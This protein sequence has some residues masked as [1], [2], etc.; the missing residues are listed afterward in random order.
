MVT[1]SNNKTK[2]AIGAVFFSVLIFGAGFYYG[3]VHQLEHGNNA[4]TVAPRGEISQDANFGTFWEAWSVL[5]EK[6]V[7]ANPSSGT[8]TSTTTDQERVYGAIQGMTESLGDPYTLFL[9]PSEN[10]V[11]EGN[12]Q[13]EFGGVGMEV[14]QR[15]GVL[16]VI[17]PLPDTPAQ[18]A[19]LEPNDK[20]LSIGGESTE[21]MSVQNAVQLIRGEKGTDVELTILSEGSQEPRE[22]AV[23]RSTIQIPTIETAETN[24]AYVI[25]LYNFSAKSPEAFRNA[26]QEFEQSGKD[27][28]VIDLRGNAGGFLQ[29]AVDVS[30]H[31]VDKE[32]VVVRESF[33]DKRDP[34]VHRSNG[35]DL[36]SEDTN[37]A[38]LVNEGSASAS[39]IVAGALR[40]HGVARL[41]GTSTF[42]KG[43]VQELVELSDN[44]ALKVTV[45]RWFTPDDT[46]ISD[47]GL[48]PDVTVEVP[49]EEEQSQAS[50]TGDLIDSQ[51][52]EVIET[53]TSN[54][55]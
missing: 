7:P 37:V 18:E 20:I 46:S 4:N 25:A 27:N 38:V 30:S 32:K 14:G 52:R 2:T 5:N 54:S 17:S 51:L 45:A 10:E 9:P 3:N 28:L 16:T 26:L 50:V 49:E 23:T 12:I 40:D 22:V 11:F 33:G 29:A 6:F 35:Y 39:E 48:E 34:R 36:V 47:G 44:T 55:Q 42:G 21:G 43:S 15:D 13:G 53:L 24:E 41:F 1:F 31:F 8:S 19:G